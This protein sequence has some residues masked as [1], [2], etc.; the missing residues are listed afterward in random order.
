MMA[1]VALAPCVAEANNDITQML[2][3]GYSAS[4]AARLAALIRS[5][6]SKLG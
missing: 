5:W 6:H 1:C 2:I 4:K 3:G